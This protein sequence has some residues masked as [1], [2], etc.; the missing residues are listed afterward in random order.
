MPGLS[1]R[2]LEVDHKNVAYDLQG[3]S[4]AP[5]KP[6]PVARE[7]PDAKADAKAAAPAAR[8]I[9]E[10]DDA[11]GAKGAEINDA[12]GAEVDDFSRRWCDG[13]TLMDAMP[14]VR[15]HGVASAAPADDATTPEASWR[16]NAL[17][18]R[19]LDFALSGASAIT[20]ADDERLRELRAARTDE[21]LFEL[22]RRW[23]VPAPDGG[24]KAS[25]GD[26]RDDG[27]GGDDDD[28]AEPKA[29]TRSPASVAD[30]SVASAGGDG[31]SDRAAR[32]ARGHA[33]RR[34]AECKAMLETEGARRRRAPRSAPRRTTRTTRTTARS[35]SSR[36]SA[37]SATAQHGARAAR[38]P[39]RPEAKDG[40][41]ADER[42][43]GARS[44]AEDEALAFQLV[45]ADVREGSRGAR[46]SSATSS[47]RA[48]SKRART[49]SRASRR[50]PTP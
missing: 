50:T 30:S 24:A 33:L 18:S 46:P 45:A 17:K 7:P 21:D 23:N 10:D 49:S 6:A 47:S 35:R 42:G 32:K 15:L 40:A 3:A 20:R 4:F 31:R 48:S 27:G 9:K 25:D 19:L 37:S 26:K 5:A 29:G 43:G 38:A 41:D 44:P 39:R 36:P 2:L 1:V 22:A 12:K 13:L 16:T 28:A 8:H 34:R 14:A 11:P